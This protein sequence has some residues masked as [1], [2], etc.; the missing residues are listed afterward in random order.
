MPKEVE[1]ILEPINIEFWF[2][3]IVD[4][5]KI[6]GFVKDIA[7]LFDESLQEAYN[8]IYA[9]IKYKL[10]FCNAKNGTDYSHFHLRFYFEKGNEDRLLVVD[11]L[12][13]KLAVHT[14]PDIPNMYVSFGD[15][16]GYVEY[17]PRYFYLGRRQFL[18]RIESGLRDNMYAYYTNR[19]YHES[20]VKPEFYEFSNLVPIIGFSIRE[21]LECIFT[22]YY[23]KGLHDY[24]DEEGPELMEQ[25]KVVIQNT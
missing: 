7:K 3:P 4:A 1:A 13:S 18:D 17:Y 14:D 16:A 19:D 15:A 6:E 20:E 12:K 22:A 8:G 2:Y 23:E 21:M 9:G 5:V 11:F 25:I 10:F 24:L